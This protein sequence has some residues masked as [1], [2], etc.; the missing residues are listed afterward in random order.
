MSIINFFHISVT[1]VIMK[2]CIVAI[3]F[4]VLI[5]PVFADDD[6]FDP[7]SNSNDIFSKDVFFDKDEYNNSQQQLNAIK[8]LP[9]LIDKKK[10][11]ESERLMINKALSNETRKPINKAKAQ[12]DYRSFINNPDRDDK[13]L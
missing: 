1:G 5:L 3:V 8:G 12:S 13:K 7:Y 10:E 4:S 6:F 9:V 2:K 11:Y